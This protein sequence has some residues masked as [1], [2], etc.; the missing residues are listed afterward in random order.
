MTRAQTI[1][2][3]RQ[4]T[5]LRPRGR[6]RV[7]APLHPE[8]TRVAR[9]ATGLRPAPAASS[10]A[11][12]PWRPGTGSPLACAS[13]RLRHSAAATRTLSEDEEMDRLV[14]LAQESVRLGSSGLRVWRYPAG[15]G[16]HP[17]RSDRREDSQAPRAD[18]A[19]GRHRSAN[20]GRP[21]SPAARV[22][23]RSA[24]GRTCRGVT[25]GRDVAGAE[26]RSGGALH[27]HAPDCPDNSH[28][29]PDWTSF[30]LSVRRE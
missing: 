21:P 5:A 11:H 3:A 23:L 2:L 4:L 18:G 29:A 14:R 24:V 30:C 16:R 9:E 27:L 10:H 17:R 25:Q 13:D 12:V 19:V 8:H 15:A 26:R 6:T 1:A 7:P 22:R 20:R 28:V